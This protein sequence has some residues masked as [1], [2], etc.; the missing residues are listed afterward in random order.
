MVIDG[1]EIAKGILDEVK[2][3]VSGLHFKPVFCDILVGSDPVS[4]SYVNIKAKTAEKCGMDF[5]PAQFPES[6]SQEDLIKEVVRLNS[7]KNICGLIVQLPLPEH[8][9]K[10]AVLEAI[11]PEIDVDCIG[12]KNLQKFY[13]GNPKFIPPTA[14]SILQVLEKNPQ[15]IEGKKILVIGQGFLVGK[16]VSYLLK[17]KGLDVSTADKD[18]K[19]LGALARQADIIISG[20]GSPKLIKAEMIKPGSVVI[21]AGTAE[22]SGQIMGDV[23]F[24]SVK[25]VAFAVTPV[26]GGIGPITVAMLLKNILQ[27]ALN[28]T[29]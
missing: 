29:A 9:S 16:P 11:N 14:G 12:E 2:S 26:P 27:V 23:D 3:A 17:A 19:D 28:K 7:V 20:T 21:D 8:L 13:S 18:V 5:Y 10:E 22:S 25:D 1:R 6:I 15:G 24:E 4:Q